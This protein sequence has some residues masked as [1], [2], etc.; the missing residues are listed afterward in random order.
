MSP[1]SNAVH[2]LELKISYLLRIGVLIAGFLL[3]LGWLWMLTHGESIS[4]KFTDYTKPMPFPERV[5]WAIISND[6]ATLISLLGLAFLVIL[7]ILRVLMT[8][9]LFIWRKEFRLGFIAFIVFIALI[10]SFFLG[11]TE[12]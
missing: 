1:L 9:I 10:S 11:F 8:G 7:P 3:C 5:H 6:P 2:Q 12:G 4:G